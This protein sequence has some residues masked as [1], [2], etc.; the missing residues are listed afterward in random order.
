MKEGVRLRRIGQEMLVASTGCKP[1]VRPKG[2]DTSRISLVRRHRGVSKVKR[3]RP[4]KLTRKRLTKRSR[5][6]S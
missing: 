1:S 2:R 5:L 6:T 3:A 4:T